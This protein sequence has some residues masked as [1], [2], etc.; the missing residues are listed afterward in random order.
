M[1]YKPQENLGPN[2]VYPKFTTGCDDAINKS[3]RCFG[4]QTAFTEAPHDVA[5]PNLNNNNLVK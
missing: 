4:T 2:E 1:R 5:A 3:L